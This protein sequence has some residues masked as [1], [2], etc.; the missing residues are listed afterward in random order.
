MALAALALTELPL[1]LTPPAVMLPSAQGE[2]QRESVVLFAASHNRGGGGW[3]PLLVMKSLMYK[4]Y[5]EVISKELTNFL[6]YFFFFLLSNFSEFM[7][8]DYQ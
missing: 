8:L 7:Q 5:G 3:G 2:H 1:H 6:H 4:E